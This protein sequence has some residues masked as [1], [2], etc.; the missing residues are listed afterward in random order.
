MGAVVRDRESTRRPFR[1]PAGRALTVDDL[2]RMPGDDGH[3][4]ELYEGT[5]LVTPASGWGHQDGVANLMDV[6]RAACPPEL[7]VYSSPWDVEFSRRSRFQPDVVVLRYDDLVADRLHAVPLLAA[8]IASPSTRDIDLTLKRKA[9]QVNGV[10]SYWL[11]E[12]DP[13]KPSVTVLELE[14]GLYVERAAVSGDD[15]LEVELPYPVRFTPSELVKGLRR[16]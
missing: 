16:G 14:D 9:Y 8:E 3:R 6:L 4:Y 2:D 13:E 11:I 12:P 7:R 1:M 10:R 15:V 5:L